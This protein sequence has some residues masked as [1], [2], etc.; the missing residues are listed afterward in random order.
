MNQETYN[1]NAGPAILPRQVF[2]EAQQ[3]II[4]F[5]NSGLS[6]LEISHRSALF[7]NLLEDTKLRLSTLLKIPDTYEIIFCPG[8]ATQQFSMVP[9]NLITEPNTKSGG[10]L[11]SGSWSIKAF[12]EAKN[13]ANATEVASSK[14]A[15][16]RLL[17]TIVTPPKNLAYVHLTSNNTIFGTQYQ[18]EPNVGELP[19]ICD[20]SS[21]I[22]S[23]PLD[24]NKYGLIYAGAQ[25]N[26][27]PAGVTLVIIKKS[28]VPEIA[29]KNKIPTMLNYRTFTEHDSCYN[30]PPVFAIYIMNLVLKWIETQGGLSVIAKLNQIKANLLYNFLEESDLFIPYADKSCR[31]RMNVTFTLSDKTLEKKF[32]EESL[33]R[34]FI[35]LEGHRSVGGFRAS[36]YNSMPVSSVERLV[37]FMQDFSKVC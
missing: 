32:A 27:G 26:L 6:I 31:S 23:R 29:E 36:I 1:F 37:E 22:L 17:P 7:S 2:I 24:I 15:N 8:G 4:N 34:N 5:D 3:G 25:K 14:S 21:D 35:G 30:T 16:F 33:K 10:Y 19:L 20:A 11:I 18:T 13:L 28:L 12:E 9:L